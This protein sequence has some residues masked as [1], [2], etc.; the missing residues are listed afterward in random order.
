MKHGPA[1]DRILSRVDTTSPDSCWLYQGAVT[2]YGYAVIWDD[3]G[4]RSG[5]HRISFERNVR[6]LKEG[7]VVDHECHNEAVRAGTCAGGWSCVHRR[8]VNPAHLRGV[9]QYQNIEG[10]VSNF[11]AR[12][13]CSKGHPNSRYRRRSKG[14]QTYCLKC[15]K[16]A[17]RE[18]EAA[19]SGQELDAI[20][21]RIGK[22]ISTAEAQYILG[23]T[24]RTIHNYI[25]R[26]LV[27]AEKHRGKMRLSEI[28]IR[29]VPKSKKKAAS[30]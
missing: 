11:H 30:K 8:C 14:G 10:S 26:G 28:D 5:A 12:E 19:R 18:R 3:D 13:F 15:R 23:V 2:K 29:K 16:D 6:P 1:M 17:E 20:E 27:R 22:T 24:R 9:Q 21:S 7:E 25:D 4:K